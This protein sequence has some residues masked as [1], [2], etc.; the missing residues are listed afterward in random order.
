M[1]SFWGVQWYLSFTI[2]PPQEELLRA[3]SI[4]CQHLESL[5]GVKVRLFYLLTPFILTWSAPQP[6]FS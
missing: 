3:C 1:M 5:A 6:S 2:H 4:D